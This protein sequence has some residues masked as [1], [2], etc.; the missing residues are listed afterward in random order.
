MKKKTKNHEKPVR[1]IFYL[2]SV[3]LQIR[4]KN[5]KSVNTK[6]NEELVIEVEGYIW[7]C[8]S[9]QHCQCT[10]DFVK[11]ITSAIYISLHRTS[12]SM[13]Y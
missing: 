1:I 5:E 6:K 2:Q 3:R 8:S 9:L 12:Y 10:N 13:C 4:K 7:F 11:T